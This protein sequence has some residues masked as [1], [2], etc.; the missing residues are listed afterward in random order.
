MR[1]FAEAGETITLGELTLDEL[2]P[3]HP[4]AQHTARQEKR[5]ARVDLDIWHP[6]LPRPYFRLPTRG[7]VESSAEYIQLQG[8]REA[9]DKHSGRQTLVT[10][11]H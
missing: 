5:N 7:P 10:K 3:P 2:P 9:G 4:T 8:R 1:M 11:A 6:R